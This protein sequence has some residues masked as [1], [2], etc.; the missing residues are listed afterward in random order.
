MLNFSPAKIIVQIYSDLTGA[1]W[2]MIF[3]DKLKFLK[4]PKLH[5]TLEG[6]TEVLVLVV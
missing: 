4:I 5:K 6:L 1:N 3:P 2:E